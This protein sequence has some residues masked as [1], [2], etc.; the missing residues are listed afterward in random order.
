VKNQNPKPVSVKLLSGVTTLV[1]ETFLPGVHQSVTITIDEEDNGPWYLSA[2]GGA[3]RI[4]VLC[5]N[6]DPFVMSHN[7]DWA[8]AIRDA[9]AEV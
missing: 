2:R 1:D 4:H 9:L 8:I 3:I 6:N 7:L 5:D